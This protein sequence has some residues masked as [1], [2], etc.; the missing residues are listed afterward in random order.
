MDNAEQVADKLVESSIRV[1]EKD[2]PLSFLVD[3]RFDDLHIF[4]DVI[5]PEPFKRWLKAVI[6]EAME[7]A[8]NSK[9]EH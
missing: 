4:L 8:V 5:D 7:E 3:N 2:G 9:R 1:F 6:L